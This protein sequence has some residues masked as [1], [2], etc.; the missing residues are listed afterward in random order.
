M[1]APT[2]Q[3]PGLCCPLRTALCLHGQPAQLAPPTTDWAPTLQ[4]CPSGVA[5][6]GQARLPC[7]GQPLGLK[8][9]SQTRPSL[10]SLHVRVLPSPRAW[11]Q[12]SPSRRLLFTFQDAPVSHLPA[13]VRSWRLPWLSRQPTAPRENGLGSYS[14]PTLQ[15]CRREQRTDYV[16]SSPKSHPTIL[17][18]GVSSKRDKW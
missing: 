16:P 3:A 13:H 9:R 11:P 5:P 4:C 7:L 15:V 1:H 18:K 17:E 6:P 10:P 8:P 14:P 12:P 2:L